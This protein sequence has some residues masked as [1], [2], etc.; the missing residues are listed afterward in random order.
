MSWSD[1]ARHR[2]PG[3]ACVKVH[4]QT[5]A[6]AIALTTGQAAAAQT[7][8]NSAPL[9]I[10]N[11]D[12]QMIENGRALFVSLG[13]GSC[14]RRSG[15]PGAKGDVGPSLDRFRVRAYIAG[16]LPN[17]PDNLLRWLMD[18]PAVSSDTAMPN[19][20]LSLEQARALAA[21]LYAKP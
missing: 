3:R 10:H 9:P 20:N 4:F 5:L 19:Q 15:V 6:I 11:A 13:C 2:W 7:Q 21:W 18:P 1:F 16:V 8:L 14:H 17:R 12:E